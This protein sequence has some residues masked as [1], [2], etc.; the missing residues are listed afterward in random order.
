MKILLYTGMEKTIEK[1][2]LGKAIQHQ[3]RALKENHIEY[4]TNPK[5]IKSCDIVHINFFDPKSYFL[6]KKAKRLGK[7][8]VYHAHSTQEDFKN[9]FLFSNQLAPLFKWWICKCYRLGDYIISPTPYSKKIQEG[10][11]LSPIEAI[12]NGIDMK[13][14]E[15]DEKLGEKFRRSYGYS[16]NDKI[17]IGIGLYLER[18]GILDFVE[19]ARR[20]PD[21]KFIW[22]GY[23]DLKLVPKKIRK[24]VKTKLANLTF[25]GYV[26]QDMIHAAL[27]GGDI[28]FFP[29][30]EETEGIPI[31]EAFTSKINTV[32]RDIPIFE[33]I[34]DG[35]EVYKGKNLEEFE[36]KIRGLMRHELPSLVDNAYSLVKTCEIKTVGKK[37]IAVYKKV[38][39]MDKE[40]T[41]KKSSSKTS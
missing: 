41:H 10:Y 12:S 5:E 4:T 8:V 38:L 18:K 16:K 20:M 11:G 25:A 22:F 36:E 14:F 40:N 21:Y 31:L 17:V 9:S 19:L 39:A 37:L 1:S 29:T 34:E 35:K 26:E 27:S 23:L 2:G 7:K 30:L 3:M 6:A 15:R 13:F 28:Y 33:W 32:I 24:A